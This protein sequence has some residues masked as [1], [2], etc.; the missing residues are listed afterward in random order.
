MDENKKT[1]TTKDKTF[2]IEIKDTQ[3]ATWQG[4][5]TWTQENKKVAFRSSLE[6]MRL[7]DSAIG[8]VDDSPQW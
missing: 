3:N 8:T 7:L 1:I 2:V 5:I 4:T 6:L